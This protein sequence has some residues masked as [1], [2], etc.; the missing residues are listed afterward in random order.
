MVSRSFAVP[1]LSFALCHSFL[2]VAAGGFAAGQSWTTEPDFAIGGAPGSDTSLWFV[3]DVSVGPQG[4]VYVAE[5]MS[6]SRVTVWDPVGT[7]ELELGRSTVA[8]GFG[9]PTAIQ[10]NSP[11]FWVTYRGSF[12]R[13]SRDGRVLDTV[14]HPPA[15]GRGFDR[16]NMVEDGLFLAVGKRPTNVGVAPEHAV[17]DWPVFGVRRVQ[18]QWITDTLTILNASRSVYGVSR[19]D[20]SRLIPSMFYT[21][22]PFADQDLVYATPRGDRVGIALRN[23]APGE[24]QLAELSVSGDTVWT[25]RVSLPPQPLGAE[26][27]RA[28]LDDITRRVLARWDP[29]RHVSE[30]ILRERVAAALYVPEH[31]PVVTSVVPAGS[32][33]MWLRS[34]EASD[35]LVAWYTFARDDD[36]DSTPRRVLLPHWFRVRDATTTHVWGTRMDSRGAGQV[37]GRRLVSPP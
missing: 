5:S 17:W 8:G 20:G 34:S 24:V 33:E 1:L 31:L 28:T 22:Q 23:G 11:G 6:A 35:S 12:V 25:R 19:D 36:P 10:P 32:G 4:K 2:L 26:L 29:G 21:S 3:V 13:Y 27:V 14:S 37:L 16:V 7:L 9:P 30:E 18:N 15:H